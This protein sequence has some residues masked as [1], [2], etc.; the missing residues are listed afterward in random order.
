MQKKSSYSKHTAPSKVHSPK[1]YQ[2]FTNKLTA[3]Q[4]FSLV[5]LMVTIAIAAILVTVAVPSLGN[6]VVQMRVDNEVSQLNRLVLTARNSA[7]SMEQNVIVCPLENGACT[8]NWSNQ[9]S[10]FIDVDNSGTYVEAVDTLLKVKAPTKAGDTVTYV[11]QNN[12]RFAPT[13]RLAN[14][15]STFIFCPRSDATLSKAI[16]LSISGATYVT[17][18]SNNDGIDELRGGGNVVGAC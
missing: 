8:N 13:G 1:L 15:P 5:E 2:S 4:G 7:I 18:D 14:A 12:I 3:N 11:G 10:A 16:V 6:F 17:S 9:L